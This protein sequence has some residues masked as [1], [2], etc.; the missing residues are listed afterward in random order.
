MQHPR[1]PD[2][3]DTIL[4]LLIVT[5]V[6]L[7]AVASGS[8]RVQAATNTPPALYPAFTIPQQQTDESQTLLLER[9]VNDIRTSEY[10]ET[11]RTSS[12]KIRTT[13]RYWAVTYATLATR[14]E[15]TTLA[16]L[17]VETLRA[18]E[19]N[20][21]PAH[22]AAQFDEPGAYSAFDIV[23]VWRAGPSASFIFGRPELAY[24]GCFYRRTETRTQAFCIFAD[25][26]DTGPTPTPTALAMPAMAT[27]RPLYGPTPTVRWG[28]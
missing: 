24:A 6:I 25:L 16:G 5:V 13:A 22:Q 8:Y 7:F 28:R 12:G 9:Y 1:H 11:A 14:F 26:L 3:P 21:F 2:W 17:I 4:G 20:A 23:R 10:G 15:G 19:F 18:N 27:P